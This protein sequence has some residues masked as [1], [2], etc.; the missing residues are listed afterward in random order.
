MAERRVQHHNLTEFFRDLV[1][2]A[3]RRQ[4]VCSTEE[5]EFYLV[6]L[7]EAFTHPDRGWFDRPLAL[8]YLEA[9]HSPVERRYG[10]LKRVGDTALFMS[11]LFIESLHRK[12]VSSDY[13]I[14]LGRTAY[15]HLSQLSAD[16]GAAP[17]DSFAELAERFPDF[18][19]VLADISLESLFPGDEQMLRVYTRWL[20]TRGKR[21]ERWL[22]RQGLIPWGASG[23]R[24]H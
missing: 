14:G 11:G 2:R 16:V 20:Y 15:G 4:E 6:K 5:T 9:F 22:I 13:Y 24:P 17:A 12:V 7:L 8:E 23:D 19:G 21:D 10:Q 1:R 18:V 3:M